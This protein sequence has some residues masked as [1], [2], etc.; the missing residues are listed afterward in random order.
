MPPKA[1]PTSEPSFSPS[2]KPTSKPKSIPSSAPTTRPIVL[3]SHLPT[4]Q[5]S[6]QPTVQP[7]QSIHAGYVTQYFYASKLCSASSIVSSYTF[8]VDDVCYYSTY[9]GSFVRNNFTR[10]DNELQIISLFYDDDLC[11][12]Y[13]GIKLKN[14]STVCTENHSF[15]IYD[16]DNYY[17]A[18][19]TGNFPS[20]NNDGLMIK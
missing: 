2:S 14:I 7:T 5:P 20:F 16:A 1:T 10:L 12:R 13:N 9:Y 3:P 17:Y 6:S 15:K 4:S 18:K 19:Y 11:Q 8:P